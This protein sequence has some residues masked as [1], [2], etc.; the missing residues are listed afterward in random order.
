VLEMAVALK[1]ENPHR[2]RSPAGQPYLVAHQ[3]GNLLRRQLSL[4]SVM[5]PGR[6]HDL[7]G[8]QR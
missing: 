2:K 4:A 1:R 6:C 7:T 3:P 5:G 8:K